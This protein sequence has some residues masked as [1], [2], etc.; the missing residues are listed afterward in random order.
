MRRNREQKKGAL[1][2]NDMFK[3]PGLPTSQA[4]CHELADFAELLAWHRDSVSSREIVAYLGRVDENDHN[5]GCDDNDDEHATDLDEVMNEIERR[6]SACGSGYPFVLRY[7]GTVLRHSVES[8]DQASVIYRYLLLC[9]RLNMKSSRIHAELDGAALFE[10]VSAEI[11][12]CYLGTG[13]AR[14]IVF[15]T[16]TVG[17]FEDKV[18]RLCEEVGEGGFFRALDPTC[19]ANDD[20]LDTVTWLPFSDKTP[21]QLVLFSQCK[22]SSNWAGL[23]TQLQPDGFIKR[24]MNTPYLLDPIRAFCV[25]EAANRAKWSLSVY[26]GLLFDRCRLVDFCGGIDTSVIEKVKTWCAAAKSTIQL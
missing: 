19:D 1:P 2:K 14:S 25:S 21:C 23:T 17:P 3:L 13:R 16:A 15:G 7:E 5:I 20:K 18:N 8:V 10:E 6:S 26:A 4:E 12:R 24:W 22:T 11:L 9:T